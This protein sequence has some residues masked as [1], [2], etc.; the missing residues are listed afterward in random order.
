MRE[1][2]SSRKFLVTVAGIITVIGNDYFELGLSK[3]SVFSVVSV[4]AAYVL[5]EG[6]ADGKRALKGEDK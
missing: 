4:I 6:Y 1:K 2:L 3:E 5:G